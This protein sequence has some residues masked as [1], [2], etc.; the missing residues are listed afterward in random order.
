M[1]KTGG[2]RASDVIEILPTKYIIPKTSSNDRKITA[3]EEIAEA[4]KNPALRSP[5][6][7]G[8]KENEIIR[9]FSEIFDRNKAN[10]TE[11]LQKTSFSGRNSRGTRQNLDKETD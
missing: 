2:T 7:N 5:F 3:L 6:M 8:K 9:E 4:V 10:A 11:K 1:E